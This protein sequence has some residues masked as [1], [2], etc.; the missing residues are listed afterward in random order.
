MSNLKKLLN[1]SKTSDSKTLVIKVISWNG[2]EVFGESLSG[3]GNVTVRLGKYTQSETSTSPRPTLSDIKANRRCDVGAI[4][5]FENAHPLK[6]AEGIWEARWCNVIKRGNNDTLNTVNMMKTRAIYGQSSNGKPYISVSM[7]PDKPPVEIKTFE[8]LLLLTQ[9]CVSINLNP[10][11]AGVAAYIELSLQDNENANIPDGEEPT[12]A[13]RA[14]IFK[15]EASKLPT[16]EVVQQFIANPQDALNKAIERDN[17]IKAAISDPT[18]TIHAVIAFQSF[19][20]KKTTEGIVGKNYKLDRLK[21]DF[22]I[23]RN[24][25]YECNNIGF[26]DA[27]IGVRYDDYIKAKYI[28]HIT[29]I[30]GLEKP[31]SLCEIINNLSGETK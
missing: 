30:D 28:V 5:V 20:G 16:G 6:D 8:D 15:K 27:V 14:I 29:T 19:C 31:R 24:C 25:S 21:R 7:I 11:S 4:L 17:V 26:K 10:K 18:I 9:K 13:S 2:E 12:S 3:E 23:D 22:T 1:V